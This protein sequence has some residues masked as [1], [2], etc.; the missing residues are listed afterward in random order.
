MADNVE[1]RIIGLLRDN[2]DTIFSISTIAKR[3]NIAYSHSHKFVKKLSAKGILKQQ[4]IGNTIICTLNL[5]NT[6]TLARLAE[7]E[8]EQT[9]KWIEKN[10]K[11]EKIFEKIEVVKDDVHSILIHGNKIILLIPEKIT[12]SDFSLFRN[13]TVMTRNQ[14]I[15]NKSYYKNAVI[16]YGAEAYIS[17]IGK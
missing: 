5:K 15:K 7:L 11:A 12:N 13:R 8:Y 2:P 9:S 6:L 3:L 1:K 14:M 10:P 4:K 16:L 17:L